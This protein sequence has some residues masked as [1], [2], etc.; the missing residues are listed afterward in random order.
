MT[1][2]EKKSENSEVF[3]KIPKENDVSSDE[4]IENDDEIEEDDESSEEDDEEIE[5]DDDDES[6]E[7][8]EEVVEN[9]G[10]TASQQEKTSD[11]VASRKEGTKEKSL[12][13]NISFVIKMIISAM[14][15]AVSLYAIRPFGSGNLYIIYYILFFLF[16]LGTIFFCCVAEKN[17]FKLEKFFV[18]FK[19]SR[20]QKSDL[21]SKDK[22]I[23][24][25]CVAYKESFLM[26][27][28]Y[29]KTRSNADLYFGGETYFN[30][31]N[32]FPVQS[33]L[34]IIPGTFIDLVKFSV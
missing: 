9:S 23:N 28:N 14:L 2:K 4:K 26:N 13:E 11:K 5:E 29:E 7:E 1:K 16:S 18:K 21:K 24:K 25:I 31:V 8:T 12:V 27:E 3:G 30:D 6:E 32:S 20:G 17:V 33:F 19:S 10:K 34:K 15:L 22:N